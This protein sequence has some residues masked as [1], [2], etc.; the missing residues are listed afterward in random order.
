M[1]IAN[2][3]VA[4]HNVHVLRGVHNKNNLK[5]GSVNIRCLASGYTIFRTWNGHA[6]ANVSEHATKEKKR[7]T[8]SVKFYSHNS[9]AYVQLR[10]IALVYCPL[11]LL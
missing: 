8:K 2:S 1:Y 11:S 5:R 3:S 10:G 6:Q 4:S 9:S 7:K